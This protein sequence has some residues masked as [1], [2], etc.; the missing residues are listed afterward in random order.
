[1][2]ATVYIEKL[3]EITEVILEDEIDFLALKNALADYKSLLMELSE[4]GNDPSNRDHIF[5]ETGK[6]IGPEWAASCIDDILRTKR[7]ICGVHKAVKDAMFRKEDKP[8]NILY[9]GTGPFATLVLPLITLYTSSEIQ[10]VFLEINP[11]TIKGLNKTIE[12]FNM[13]AYIDSIHECDAATFKVESS[14]AIDVVI[15]EC[16]QH[17]L[18]REP[19]VAITYNLIEQLPKEVLLIPEEISLHIALLNI[20]KK[21][22][23]LEYKE[24]VEPY[25]FHKNSDP[26]FVLNKVEVQKRLEE[27]QSNIFDFPEV[28][29][30]FSSLDFDDYDQIAISTEIKVYK[31]EIL[32]FDNSGLTIPCILKVLQDK[33]KPSGV[34][35]K[36]VVSESPLL[37]TT[38]IN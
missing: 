23:Q 11:I 9:S 21:N 25:P 35:S 24:G 5:L 3:T 26:V 8:I 17:A 12:K 19:Q 31:D 36:Y 22:E 1:M 14:D 32:T 33:N 13:E 27:N 4:L 28:K 29:T 10:F 15:I 38:F 34:I 2:E 16:L 7:F 37:E 30:L 18:A 20:A 6:A